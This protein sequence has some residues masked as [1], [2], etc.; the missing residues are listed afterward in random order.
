VLHSAPCAS[1]STCAIGPSRL[2][3]DLRVS[4]NHS[5]ILSLSPVINLYYNHSEPRSLLH[6]AS[7]TSAVA[8]H[9]RAHLCFARPC[10]YFAYRTGYLG[11]LN[12]RPAFRPD[13]HQIYSTTDIYPCPSVLETAQ[14]KVKR[15]TRRNSELMSKQTPSRHC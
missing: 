3:Q 10:T 5:T 8:L 15:N 4:H 1:F 7:N 2:Y 14:T 6:I 12:I 13:I 11:C 9:F